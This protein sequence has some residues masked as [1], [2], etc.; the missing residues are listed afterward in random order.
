MKTRILRFLLPAILIAAGAGSVAWTWALAQ[1]VEHLEA[2]GKQSAARIDRLEALLDEFAQS[3]LTY[4]ASGQIDKETL[5]S[6]SA[7]IRQIASESSWLL[8]QLLAGAAP[9]AGALAD[10]VASLAEVDRRARE[11][12]A[13][14]LDLMAADLLFSETTRTRQTMREQLRTLRVAESTA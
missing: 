11:N 13:A 10:G 8:G 9:S 4:A 7:R 3:E 1:H 2:T 5:I 14:D 6:T 12:V